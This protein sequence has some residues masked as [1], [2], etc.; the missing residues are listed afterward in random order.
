MQLSEIVKPTLA[1][2]RTSNE[3]DLVQA[4]QSI[5]INQGYSLS[6][7]WL[8]NPEIVEAK[9]A[10]ADL[11]R[12]LISRNLRV[13]LG[14]SKHPTSIERFSLEYSG[15]EA[16]WLKNVSTYVVPALIRIASELN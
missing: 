15:N 1:H 2:P 10:N 11:Q 9:N 14:M 5:M 12:F 3:T 7:D 8:N 16:E 13:K 4:V 6:V